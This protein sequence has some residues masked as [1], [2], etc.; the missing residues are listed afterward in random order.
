M[1]FV[2]VALCLVSIIAASLAVAF[3]V[4]NGQPLRAVAGVAVA[5]LAA[6]GLHRELREERP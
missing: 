4:Y 3:S 6:W 2:V 5:G 1:R